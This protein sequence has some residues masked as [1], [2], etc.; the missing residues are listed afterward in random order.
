[1]ENAKYVNSTVLWFVY[2]TYTNLSD[3]MFQVRYC[4]LILKTPHPSSPLHVMPGCILVSTMGGVDLFGAP[5]TM[6]ATLLR[7]L[8]RGKLVR[9]KPTMIDDPVTIDDSMPHATVQFDY[10]SSSLGFSHIYLY[11]DTCHY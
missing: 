8:P 7:L 4:V 10:S 6:A 11:S 9:Q 2:K 1:M 5:Y 3:P